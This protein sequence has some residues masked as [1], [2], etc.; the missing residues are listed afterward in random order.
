[1][2]LILIVVSVMCIILAIQLINTSKQYTDVID[3]YKESL[4]G[5]IA[6]VDTLVIE[7]QACEAKYRKQQTIEPAGV[8]SE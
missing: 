8:S 5:S 1:M 4:E 2:R 7:L 6:M 3:I